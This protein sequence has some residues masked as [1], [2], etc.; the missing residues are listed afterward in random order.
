[1]GESGEGSF[2]GHF[3]GGVGYG[4][5]DVGIAGTTAE[6]AVQT[7][8]DLLAGRVRVALEQ[9]DSGQDHAGSAETALQAVAFPEAFL[10]W[11]QL[12]VGGEPLDSGHF[13]S[14]GLDGE[15]SAGFDG[16]AVKEDGAGT[17]QAGFTADVRA[18]KF[19]LVANEMDEKSAGIHLVLLFD[20]VDP[21]RY[22]TFHDSSGTSFA[23]RFGLL[24]KE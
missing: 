12:T 23:L 3:L 18:G 21:D 13:S 24:A 11:M 1:M 4:V 19:A 10:H 15:E 9:L 2:T 17:A 5:Y 22:Q 6:V 7:V 8:S 20:A 14:V 16:F